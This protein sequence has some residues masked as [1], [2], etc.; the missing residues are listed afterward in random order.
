[1]R[2]SI[3]TGISLFWFLVARPLFL[4]DGATGT[5]NDFLADVENIDRLSTK[6]LASPLALMLSGPPGTGKTLLAGHIAARL[7]RPFFVARLDSVISSLLGDTS[8]NIRAVF[9]FVPSRN[10]VLFLDEM[11]AIAKLRDDRHEL[12]ELKR[13]VNTVIQGLDT[14]DAHAVVVGAS[15]HAHLLDP[16]IWRSPSSSNRKCRQRSARTSGTGLPSSIL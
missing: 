5:F 4:G 9:E 6:G 11:D 3:T 1:L 14:L 10:A 15:N 16:A 13:V 8:K 2:L 7:N 12:G